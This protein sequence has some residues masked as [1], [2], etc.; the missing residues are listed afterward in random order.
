MFPHTVQFN[1]Q[2]IDKFGIFDTFHSQK[3][4][5]ALVHNNEEILSGFKNSKLIYYCF[6][7]K[8][9]EFLQDEFSGA[10]QNLIFGD[11]NNHQ[12]LL[13]EIFE[14]YM[15]Q[16]GKNLLVFSNSIGY[17]YD[18]IQRVFN[19]LSA[20]DETVVIGKTKKFNVA[21]IGFNSVNPNFLLDMDLSN[22]NLDKLLYKV[23]QR[24]NLVHV[25]GNYML[26]KN[27]EDFK[28]LY[29]E[30]SKKESLSYCSHRMHELFTNLFIEYK[31][32]LK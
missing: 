17:T 21:Y 24:D 7:E 4:Y 16:T 2:E 20:E 32:I 6:D 1:P 29:V 22:I 8:D 9:K 18:D 3:L 13:K 14:K 12:K 19:L 11:T 23:N 27:I 28:D 31:E 30:L 10:N 5:S 26:I 15:P 25:L